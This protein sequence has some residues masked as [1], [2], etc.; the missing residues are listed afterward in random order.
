MQFLNV[1][2]TKLYVTNLPDNCDKIELQLL[3]TKY[4]RV[5]ECV[6]MWNH[7]A[8]VHFATPQEA[9]YALY[10]LNGCPFFGKNLI[11]Q[12][13][14]SSNRPLPKC[15]AFNYARLRQNEYTL[16][17][18]MQQQQ[19]QP[20]TQ[21]F[22]QQQF[23]QPIGSFKQLQ[24]EPPSIL[25]YRATD[26]ETQYRIEPHMM[27][28]QQQQQQYHQQPQYNRVNSC[29]SLNDSLMDL[30]RNKFEMV[31]LK[32]NLLEILNTTQTTISE[33][34]NNYHTMSLDQIPTPPL[35]PP[36]QPAATQ[37]SM[38][39]EFG[40]EVGAMT[41]MAPRCESAASISP[42]TRSSSLSSSSYSDDTCDNNLKDYGNQQQNQRQDETVESYS[43]A[44]SSQGPTGLPENK[45]RSRC[46]I[47]NYLLN[48]AGQEGNL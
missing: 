30:I 31:S 40:D 48:P 23:I 22:P 11:V 24:N 2:E 10:H 45:R 27:M 17:Q 35:P 8:F 12:L 7:Y 46:R 38:K 43:T 33:Q 29:N 39:S 1:V 28:G 15:I 41:T 9:N 26:L 34:E 19:M 32:S 20:L 13:S 6:V 37:I 14:T 21:P 44:T 47:I 36:P 42:T 16:Q 5:L 3:F 25:C 18:I 4:G